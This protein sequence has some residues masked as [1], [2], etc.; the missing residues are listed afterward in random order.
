[1]SYQQ[2]SH[3]DRILAFDPGYAITGYAVI[4]AIGQLLDYGALKTDS[5]DPMNKRLHEIYES[6]KNL[7]MIHHPAAVALEKLYFSK[8]TTT[9][10][11]V[12]EARGCILAASFDHQ[13]EIIELDPSAIKKGLTGKGN[14]SKKDMI[15][16]VKK[17]IHGMEDLKQDDTADAIALAIVAS[18]IFRSPVSRSLHE[19]IGENRKDSR[20]VTVKSFKKYIKKNYKL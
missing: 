16:M 8:N 7:C 11:G 10:E 3:S 4:T 17:I 20:R 13:T 15:L 12:F 18:S 5:R 6:V 1:M 19:Q 2:A 14:S 9:A